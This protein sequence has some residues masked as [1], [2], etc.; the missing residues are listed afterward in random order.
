MCFGVGLL[1][2][3]GIS[4]QFHSEATLDTLDPLPQDPYIQVYFNQNQA[5]FYTD[6]YRQITRHGDDLE[7]V[8]VDAIASANVS[9]DVAVHEFSLPGVALALAQRQQDGIPVR[10]VIENTYNISMADRS[11]STIAQMEDRARTKASDQFQLID[12]NQDGVL[13][14]DELAARDALTIL[15]QAHIPLIDDT[16]DGS[17][18]SGLMHH[19]FMVVDGRT[20]ITGSAN[21]TMSCVHGDYAN[22]DSRGNANSL[23]VIESRELAQHFQA[24]FNYMWGDGPGGA[25]DSL[26]GLQKPHRPSSLVSTPGSVLEVQFS[27]TSRTIPWAESVNGLI[28]KTLG[29]ASRTIHLALFVFSEQAISDQLWPLA[30]RGVHI[31]T[32]I[33][34]GFAYR[35]Y[36]EGLDML[37]IALPDHRCQW[38]ANNRP[39][40]TPIT[41]VGVPSLNDGDKLHHKFAVM[42]QTTVLIGSQNWSQ[43][44]N[45]VNDENLLMIRNSTVAAHFEREFQRLYEDA[46]LGLTPQLQRTKARLRE[47]C[48]AF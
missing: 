2:V 45:T 20:V 26:F 36:S 21:W 25:A 34:P 37:G 5:A 19:K 7:Q 13:S 48:G 33:D 38:D 14:D 30:Q 17:K 43:A 32:L 46:R 24:E 41:T 11:R 10:I 15:A 28:A 4:R 3:L 31:K 9:I 18:G 42:D 8:L 6:P 47:T 44:A 12:T 35:S 23:V 1:L 16:A 39:W 22:P 29:Q 40:P 27:P